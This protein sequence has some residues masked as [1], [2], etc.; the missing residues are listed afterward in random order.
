MKCSLGETD[1]KHYHLNLLSFIDFIG[2]HVMVLYMMQ[3]NNVMVCTR[4]MRLMCLRST[5]TVEQN[6]PDQNLIKFQGRIRLFLIISCRLVY[7]ALRTSEVFFS[8]VLF[9]KIQTKLILY[10]KP[11]FNFKHFN[12]RLKGLVNF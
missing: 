5:V 8:P 1:K 6:G 3:N 10:M 12:D 9:Q 11:S 2:F 7:V 4:M